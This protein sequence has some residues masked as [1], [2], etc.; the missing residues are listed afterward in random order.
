[1]YSDLEENERAA[2]WAETAHS[3]KENTNSHLWKQ[4][5]GYYKMHIQIT[6]VNLD[7]NEDEIFPM[8]GNIIA[9]QSGLANHTQ[10]EHIFETAR[11]RRLQ[12]NASTIGCVL[13]PAYSADFFRNHI[14]D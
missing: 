1:M 2:F 4:N 3:I 8:G 5:K 12:V 9:I 11:E 10:A 6:P 13:I 7:F 14:M